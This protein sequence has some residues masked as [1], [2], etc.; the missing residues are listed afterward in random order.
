MNRPRTPWRTRRL[1]N[2]LRRSDDPDVSL[3]QQELDAREKQLREAH[4]AD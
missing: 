3:L 2:S 4:L 1:L